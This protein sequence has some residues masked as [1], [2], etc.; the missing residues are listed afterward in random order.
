LPG[1]GNEKKKVC[2]R[3]GLEH[4]RRKKRKCRGNMCQ[5]REKEKGESDIKSLNGKRMKRER[6]TGS[7]GSPKKN[8]TTERR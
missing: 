4:V 5:L 7:L 3:R 1:Q 8:N 6:N 2:W